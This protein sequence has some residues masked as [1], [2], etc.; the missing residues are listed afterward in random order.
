MYNT[1]PKVFGVA[2][3]L[4]TLSAISIFTYACIEAYEYEHTHYRK[5]HPE[6]T[7]KGMANERLEEHK[8]DKSKDVK[9]LYRMNGIWI[10]L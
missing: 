7:C 10:W 1:S 8:N 3:I 6:A 5:A 9:I 4:C 2:M